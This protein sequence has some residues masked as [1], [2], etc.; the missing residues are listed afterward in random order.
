MKAEKEAQRDKKEGLSSQLTT[1]WCVA[2]RA[3]RLPREM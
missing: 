1:Y 3:D 2:L